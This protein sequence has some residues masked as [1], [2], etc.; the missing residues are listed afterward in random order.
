MIKQ[1][2]RAVDVSLVFK[3][4]LFFFLSV[5]IVKL[6]SSFLKIIFGLFQKI[7]EVKT[8]KTIED[9]VN[10]LLHKEPGSSLVGNLNAG[11]NVDL[12]CFTRPKE[13]SEELG[14]NWSYEKI[15]NIYPSFVFDEDIKGL[16][17]NNQKNVF[18]I[19][20]DGSYKSFLIKALYSY[21]SAKNPLCFKNGEKYY[22]INYRNFVIIAKQSVG[23]S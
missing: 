15:K 7:N 16:S 9:N 22:L 12:I 19:Y 5:L 23:V 17:E 3:L 8:V 13:L 2:K 18:F 1:L 10:N 11:K 14:F 4:L 6:S 21:F 20:K